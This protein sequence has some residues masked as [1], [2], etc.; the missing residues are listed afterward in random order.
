[1]TAITMTTVAM[2]QEF[3]RQVGPLVS[4]ATH[5]KTMVSCMNVILTVSTLPVGV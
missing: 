4:N 5:V 2:L 3:S 1:M